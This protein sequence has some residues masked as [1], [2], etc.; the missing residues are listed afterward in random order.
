MNKK[1]LRKPVILPILI[2]AAIIVAIIVVKTRP[3]LEHEDRSLHPRSVN[4]IKANTVPTRIKSIGYGNV[5]PAVALA[6]KA[7]VS[8]KIS[9]MHPDLKQGGSLPKDTVVLRIDAVDYELSLT[10]G[11]AGLR[12]SRS[13]LE[14]LEIEEKSTRRS[15]S[16]AKKNLQVGEAEL[17]RKKEIR[18]KNLISK[19]EVDAEEQKVL[20]LR[21][22][23]EDLQGRLN[24]FASR[25]ASTRAQIEQ[26][27]A[28]AE[29]Q[30]ETP[31][32]TGIR[33][34]RPRPAL[35]WPSPRTNPSSSVKADVS[36]AKLRAPP[37]LPA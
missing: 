30:Q 11:E 15:L 27:A 23:V 37:V 34:S 19:T 1:I 4:V 33:H 13:A 6:A 36:I 9:Y 35:P 18:A 28:Q 17:E 22:T 5:E 7:E 32:R 24:A 14:Q 29:G 12:S 16:L 3:A 21:Q 26:S 10:G 31:G 8:G 20:A 25:K 2:I